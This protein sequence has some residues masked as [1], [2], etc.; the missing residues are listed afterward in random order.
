MQGK[1]RKVVQAISYEL[2]ALL[3]IAPSMAWVFDKDLASSGLV[4]LMLSLL[5]MSWSMLFNTWFEGWEARQ[6]NPHRSFGRRLLHAMGFE[7]GLLLLTVPLLA[8][9]LG[10]RWWEALLADFSL[11]IFFLFYALIF[12]WCFDLVFG[13]PAATLEPAPGCNG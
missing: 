8:F 12:Q 1:K 5:A 7:C 3:F 4:T 2:V 11:L 13:P 6:A 10:I 9:G